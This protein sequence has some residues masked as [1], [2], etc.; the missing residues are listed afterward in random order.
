M[1]EEGGDIFEGSTIYDI[2]GGFKIIKKNP[3]RCEMLGLRRI[4]NNSLEKIHTHA[5]N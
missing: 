5:K 4:S 2:G 1:Q 3:K